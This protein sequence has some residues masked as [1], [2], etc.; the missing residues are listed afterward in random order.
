MLPEPGPDE[1]IT[2]L[3][4]ISRIVVVSLEANSIQEYGV[5]TI[6]DDA[7]GKHVLL[8]LNPSQVDLFEREVLDSIRDHLKERGVTDIYLIREGKVSKVIKL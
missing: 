1:P 2:Q 8:S 3:K 6:S 7:G 4:D 5:A